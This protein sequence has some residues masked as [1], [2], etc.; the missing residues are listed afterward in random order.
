MQCDGTR[1]FVLDL[2][3]KNELMQNMI[4]DKDSEEM[5]ENSK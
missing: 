3:E 1:C 2:S 4:E 5:F